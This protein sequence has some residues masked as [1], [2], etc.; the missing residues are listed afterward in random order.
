MFITDDIS[1]AAL[2][3]ELL[4][5][6]TRSSE[7][8]ARFRGLQHNRDLCPKFAD[9]IDAMLDVYK[10]HRTDVHDI[11][12]VRDSGVDVLLQFKTEDDS[13]HKVG[14]QLK[15]FQEIEDARKPER[16]VSLAGPKIPVRRGDQQSIR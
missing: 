2:L 7:Q 3:A 1:P 12:G 4:A 13:L 8:T 11:Q 10:R 6:R 5:L 14:I 15:S 16:R 9:R